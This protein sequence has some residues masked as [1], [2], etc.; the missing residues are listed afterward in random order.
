VLEAKGNEEVVPGWYSWR[1]GRHL[2]F[3]RDA[4]GTSAPTWAAAARYAASPA[5][6][7]MFRSAA[8]T[9]GRP[10]LAW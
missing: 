5:V 4:D 6:D 1:G 7:V 2:T 10:C 9:F 8:T 3:R